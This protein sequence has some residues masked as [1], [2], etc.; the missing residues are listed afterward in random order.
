MSKQRVTKRADRN[1]LFS[2]ARESSIRHSCMV[3][4]SRAPCR[5]KEPNPNPRTPKN[6]TSPVTSAESA[7]PYYSSFNLCFFSLRPSGVYLIGLVSWLHVV[8]CRGTG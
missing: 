7:V 2:L 1:H 4:P 3:F 6:I 8:H 5:K